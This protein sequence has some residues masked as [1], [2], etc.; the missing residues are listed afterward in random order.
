[1]DRYIVKEGTLLPIKKSG[2]FTA[3]TKL[4]MDGANYGE[5]YSIYSDQLNSL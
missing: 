5:I 3:F 2:E 4:T 1:M